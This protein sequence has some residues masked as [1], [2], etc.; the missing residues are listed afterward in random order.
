[1]AACR[2]CLGAVSVRPNRENGRDGYTERTPGGRAADRLV[3][4]LVSFMAA[5]LAAGDN[6]VHRGE[7]IGV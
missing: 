1:M 4:L 5:S 3:R 2:L 6:I 7:I